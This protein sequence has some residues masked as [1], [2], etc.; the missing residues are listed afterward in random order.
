[1]SETC[2]ARASDL[3][4]AYGSYTALAASSFEIP[5]G[6]VTAVIGPN[7]S[8]KSTVLHALAGLIK[9]KQGDIEVLG[10]TPLAARRRVSYVL[11]TVAMPTGTPITVRE[12]VAM[13]RYSN[14]G[15]WRRSTPADRAKVDWAINELDVNDL[16]RR[17]LGELSG[18][19]R[20][21]VYMAQGI[22]QDHDLLLLDEPLT[23]LDLVSART[24]DRIIHAERDNSQTVVLTTHD[25]DEARAA[26]HVLL[27]SGRVVASGPPEKVLTRHNLEVAYGLGALHETTHGFIDDPHRTTDHPK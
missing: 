2:A 21:R 13:A 27:V 1:M 5:A 9:P 4:L 16:Q 10:D 12:T 23:G 20:Q 22:A 24:I 15:L 3:V 8:G 25:L 6:K 14:L 7:G 26:D 11:Q 17:H 19:Q 18:G